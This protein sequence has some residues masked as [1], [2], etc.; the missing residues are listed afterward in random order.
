MCGQKRAELG[1]Q[2]VY[3]PTGQKFA[4]M[5]GSTV[6]SYVVPL[7]GGM[8]AVY[9]SSGLEYYRHADWLGSSWFASTPGGGVYADQAYA[10]FGETFALRQGYT[11][12]FD[13]TGQTQD[14]TAGYYDFLFRQQSAV[15][16]RWLVPD[17][18][19]LA[20]VDITNPQTW[21]RYAYV[22]NN[23]L[24][25][26]DPLGLKCGVAAWYGSGG[27]R[28]IGCGGFGDGGFD[29]GAWSFPQFEWVGPTST[30]TTT[31]DPNTGLQAFTFSHTT[32]YW[33]LASM[34]SFAVWSSSSASL[35][36]SGNLPSVDNGNTISVNRSPSNGTPSYQSPC[37]RN[38]LLAGVARVGIDA[39]GLIPEAGGIARVIGHQAGYV[40]VVADQAG[41]RFI[42]AVGGSTSTVSGLNGLTDTSGSGLLST[43]LT[44]AGFIPGLNDAAA[45]GSIGLDL[46]K[47]LEAIRQCP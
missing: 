39:V 45:V 38:A 23:P 12:L 30:E 35:Y 11:G 32:G 33:Q 47:T 9:N 41:T 42:Q 18:A 34:G 27:Y 13:F 17:P 15:E 3:S 4:F 44:V 22:M 31:V 36:Q 7:V 2:S 5:N 24:S 6:Q 46:F 1:S 37:V 25:Y 26:I 28:P 14:T 43:G 29:W 16:G 19:G 10:P 20:A 21:N 8:Q 40:G